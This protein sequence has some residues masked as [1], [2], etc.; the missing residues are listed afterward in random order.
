MY[1][2]VHGEDLAKSRKTIIKLYSSIKEKIADIYKTEVN[3]SDVSAIEFK[4]LLQTKD[5]FA[6]T[7]FVVLNLEK[8]RST[9]FL[10]YIKVIEQ[11]KHKAH[12]IVVADKKLTKSNDFLKLANKLKAKVFLNEFK[13]K[14]NVFNFVDALVSKNRKRTYKEYEKL[15]KDGADTFYLI[16]MISYGF[17]TLVNTKYGTKAGVA[18]SPYVKNKATKQSSKY[19]YFKLL[20][21]Y[22][23][24]YE[25]DLKLKT[26]GITK[27]VAVPLLIEKVLV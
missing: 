2:V 8:T 3:I 11:L 26:G 27:E 13:P 23:T 18:M 9:K 19:D 17:R 16:S 12:I 6:A 21:I 15:L 25:T 7:P 4:E 1:T 22:K 24:L 10:E 14:G 20:T 5:L